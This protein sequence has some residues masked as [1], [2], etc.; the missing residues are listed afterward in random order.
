MDISPGFEGD[1]NHSVLDIVASGALYS[2]VCDLEIK[3]ILNYLAIT[4][5]GILGNAIL[6]LGCEGSIPCIVFPNIDL[7]PIHNVMGLNL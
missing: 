4:F 5:L 2:S 7:C 1:H 3:R 6:F